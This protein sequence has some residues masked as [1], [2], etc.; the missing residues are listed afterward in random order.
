MLTN[1]E[2][3]VIQASCKLHN[4]FCSLPIF[5]VSDIKEEV[6]HIHAI[7]NMI[8]AR[9]AYR[10]D[11]KT[12]PVKNGNTSNVPIGI[13]TSTPMTFVNLE[14]NIPVSSGKCVHQKKYRMKKMRIKKVD[15]TYFS[16]SKY[17]RLEEQFQANN[18]QTAYLLQIR[19]LGIWFTIRMNISSDSHY[20]LLCVTEALE[21]LQEKI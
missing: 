10:S 14:N 9:E 3:E 5:H 12:F 4:L 15:V 18:F 6:F 7:Q 2:K 20:A 13:I 19:I 1:K 21:K 16:L 11:P 8:M 17:I